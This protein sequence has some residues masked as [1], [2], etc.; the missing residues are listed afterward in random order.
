MASH[1]ELEAL[2][3]IPKYHTRDL[4]EDDAENI[5]RLYN[6]IYNGNYPCREYL[7]EEWVKSQVGKLDKFYKIIVDQEDNFVGCGMMELDSRRGVLYGRA[8]AVCLKYQEKGIMG[9]IGMQTAQQVM[10]ELN[11]K[12]KMFYCLTRTT[13]GDT[14]M[15][16]TLEKV[17]LR[18]IAILPD[19]DT[20]IGIRE[21][22]MFQALIFTPAFKKRRKNP[23][24]I[25]EL[26]NILKAVRKQYRQVK[27]YSILEVD[28]I[29]IIKN[30]IMIGTF[31]DV[32]EYYTYIE[33]SCNQNHIKIE[34]N[35]KAESAEVLEYN[36]QDEEIFLLL[37][38]KIVKKMRQRN[39]KYLESYVSA[40]EPTHQKAFIQAG[41]KA[42][43]YIPIYDTVDG[44]YEDRV[45]MSWI[46]GEMLTRCLEF[47]P[48]SWSFIKHF[49]SDLGLNGTTEEV[50][51]GHVC[52]KLS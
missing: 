34:I 51:R 30:G 7:D 35:P 6:D 2:K 5:V 44:Q 13:P 31:E 39:I 19:L 50:D 29:P 21:T 9:G 41:F 33:L 52:F 14:G 40:Y 11:G 25:P 3:T 23:V 27:D 16:R 46:P 18:P 17:G 45:H 47:T 4:R 15:Q 37:L 24:V 8:T 12:I 22:E 10:N 20:G 49:I 42:T 48:R 32:H 36:C 28:N 38:S 26:K 1:A 43:G